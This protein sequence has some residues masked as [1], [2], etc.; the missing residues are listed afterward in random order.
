MEMH[1]D[2]DGDALKG[3]YFYENHGQDIALEGRIDSSDAVTLTESDQGQVTGHWKVTLGIDGN[4]QG[5][6]SDA[7]GKKSFPVVLRETR[8]LLARGDLVS[9]GAVQVYSAT[10]ERVGPKG[11]DCTRSDEIPSFKGA[12]NPEAEKALA[13]LAP[14]AAQAKLTADD[15]D[16]CA[17]ESHG[18]TVTLNQGLLFSIRLSEESYCGGAHPNHGSSATTLDLRTG[19]KLSLADLFKP[20]PFA[21]LTQ[22]ATQQLLAD[23]QVASL[24]DSDVGEPVIDASTDWYLSPDGL[25]FHWSPYGLASYARGDVEIVLPYAALRELALP[26]GPLGP[27]LKSKG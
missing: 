6:W 16:S 25:V 10:V 26:Q 27:L 5:T 23:E 11:D 14:R 8:N 1:L 2:R 15:C 19:K 24:D 13:A 12:P 18:F 17:E 22:L 3:S 21:T 7:K 4:L 9:S 20:N